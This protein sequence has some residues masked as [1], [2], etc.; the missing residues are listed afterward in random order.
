[1]VVSIFACVLTPDQ[2]VCDVV[3]ASQYGCFLS[4]PVI[5]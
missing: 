3:V 1:M 2:L 5:G 4:S